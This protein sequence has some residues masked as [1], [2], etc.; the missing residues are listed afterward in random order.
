MLTTFAWGLGFRMSW[1]AGLGTAMK[2]CEPQMAHL[3]FNCIVMTSPA[4]SSS[5]H[6]HKIFFGPFPKRGVP[7]SILILLPPSEL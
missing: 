4:I 7:W 5:Q 2:Y 6:W 1:T 3:P